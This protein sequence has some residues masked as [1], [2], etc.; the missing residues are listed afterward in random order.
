M[1]LVNLLTFK[2][3]LGVVDY[4]RIL[5][6]LMPPQYFIVIIVTVYLF[7]SIVFAVTFVFVVSA[8]MSFNFVAI[9]LSV[10]SVTTVSN[11]GNR[12]TLRRKGSKSK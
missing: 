12:K 10:L 2:E 3:H 4:M 6:L 9:S 8:V 5:N 7:V 11:Y 1:E